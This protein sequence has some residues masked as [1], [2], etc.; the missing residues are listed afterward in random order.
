MWL[1]KKLDKEEGGTRRGKGSG[2]AKIRCWKID[3]I[4]EK[5]TR[6]NTE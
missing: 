3:Q 2:S 5:Q 6:I 1:S 4:R